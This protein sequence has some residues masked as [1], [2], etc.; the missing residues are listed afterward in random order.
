MNNVA[1]HAI[2]IHSC[3]NLIILNWNWLASHSVLYDFLVTVNAA[4]H[5]CVSRTGQ[6][7]TEVK[8]E[9]EV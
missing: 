5:E 2:F 8:A 6:P 9:N 4:P 7:R 1:L 3:K